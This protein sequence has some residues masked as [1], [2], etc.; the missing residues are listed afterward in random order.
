MSVLMCMPGQMRER[1]G[2]DGLCAIRDS[3][4]RVHAERNPKSISLLLCPLS[5]MDEAPNNKR[6]KRESMNQRGIGRVCIT[7]ANVLSDYGDCA[8]AMANGE[9]PPKY[10]NPAIY[11]LLA[12]PAGA[13]FAITVAT[14][15]SRTHCIAL[16]NNT[17]DTCMFA[18]PARG[19]FYEATAESFR[20]R[21]GSMV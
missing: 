13:S 10:R 6:V 12:K 14:G 5:Q 1:V 4:C 11:E 17:D 15:T 2:I 18:D 19:G 8:V 7:K 3:A 9:T 20:Q 21:W 16:L